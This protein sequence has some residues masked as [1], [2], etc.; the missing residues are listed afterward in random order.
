MI[1]LGIDYGASNIGI[2]L[3]RNTKTGNEVLFA[4]TIVIDHMRIKEKVEP[5]SSIRSLRRTRKTKKARLREL[6]SKLIG[7]KIQQELIDKIVRF[8]ERRGYSY[9][10]RNNGDKESKEEIQYKIHREKF[11]ISLEEELSRILSDKAIRGEVVKIAERVLN[12]SCNP[13]Q[14]PR[15]ARFDNRG[16]SRCA[17]EGCDNVTPRRVNAID[18]A[19]SQQLVTYFQEFLKENR[20]SL[21]KVR[22]VAIQLRG[23]AKELQAAIKQGDKDE[24]KVIKKK[25]RDSL[26]KLRGELIGPDKITKD[27]D[28]AWKYVKDGLI[29]ILETQGGRNSYCRKHSAAYIETILDGK[30][31]PFKKTISESDIVSRREQIIFGKLWRYIEARLL[32]LVPGGIDR[33]VVER[34]AFDILAGRRKTI[35]ATSKQRI[36]DIYQQGPMYGFNSVGEMLHTEFGGLCAYCGKPSESFLE[37]EHILPRSQFFFD[38]YLNIL[39]SCPACNAEKGARLPG[40]SS[41]HINEE[42]YLNYKKYLDNMKTKRPLHYLHTEKMGLLNLMQEPGRSWEVEQYL[43]LIANSFASIGQS[44][45]GPRPLARFLNSKLF[46]SQPKSPDIRFRNGR[47]TALYRTIAYPDFYKRE[48]K[49]QGGKVNHALDAVILACKLPDPRPLEVRGINTHAI[50]TWRRN[51]I[52]Q[53]P[54]ASTGGL[55]AVPNYPWYV[56]DFEAVDSGYVTVEMARINWNQRDSATHKQDPYGWSPK[57]MKPTKRT[58]A[59]ELYEELMKERDQKKIVKITETISHPQLRKAMADVKGSPNL[60]PNVAGAMKKW[61]RQSVQNSIKNSVFSNHPADVARK[62][63]LEEFA[64]NEDGPIP[65]VIGIKRFD[66]GVQGKVDLERLDVQTKEIGHRYMA[67]PANRAMVLAYPCKSNGEADFSMPYTAGVRQNSS[68]KIEGTKF[69]LRPELLEKGVVWGNKSVSAYQ[70]QKTLEEYLASCGFHSYI[71]LAPCCVVRYS[72]GKEKFIR[73]FDK[74]KEFKKSILKN[75]VGIRRTPFSNRLIAL[76]ILTPSSVKS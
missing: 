4:G 43:G 25:A 18:D 48:D 31:P 58:S 67:D 65:K 57:K 27:M 26:Q 17:W 76:K 30:Q 9:E 74:S 11:F 36:E 75:I 22:N 61:L 33:I 66:T 51:V 32:P 56:E 3:V 49:L 16:I 37:R 41:L 15:P 60:G 34:T 44:Q 45:R 46:L 12:R 47:H 10:E 21:G 28:D 54:K 23:L 71:L 62:K 19:V 5:R 63:Q 59:L 40:P 55:P 64:N 35:N 72:G 39:P 69:R 8:C 42:A 68:L 14:E 2:A 70:W 7:L 1:T 29:N 24:K 6:K 53:A 50:G 20:P 38:S 13:Q 52:S 73:N